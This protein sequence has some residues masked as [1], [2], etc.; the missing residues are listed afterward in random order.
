MS[1]KQLWKVCSANARAT[2][3]HAGSAP[4]EIY[5]YCGLQYV[6]ENNREWQNYL[7]SFAKYVYERHGGIWQ[8]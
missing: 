5:P 2:L 7:N 3:N 6:A 1:T 8:D 4:S